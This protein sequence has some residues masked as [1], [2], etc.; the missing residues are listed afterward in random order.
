MSIGVWSK[1]EL[2]YTFQPSVGSNNSYAGNCDVAIDGITWNITGNSTLIPWRLGGKSLS[3]VNRAIYSKTAISE[4]V[5]K[6]VITHGAASSITVNSV[7]VVVSKNSDFSSPISTLSLSFVANNTI[8]VN[9]PDE[10]DWS[11]CYY[12]IVYNVTVSSTSNKFLEFV[13]AKFY[14]EGTLYSVVFKN[15]GLPIDTLYTL[16]YMHTLPPA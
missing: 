7:T 5:T 2:V 8:T 9:R 16:N 12:K 3:G 4:N 13:D 11:D 10:K 1:E 14:A 15:N 6:I